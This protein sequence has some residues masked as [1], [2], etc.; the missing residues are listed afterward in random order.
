MDAVAVPALSAPAV[1]RPWTWWVG[2]LAAA[3]LGLVMLVAVWAKMLDPEAFTEQIRNE[4]LD[5]LLSASAVALVALF[6]EAGFGVG[7]LLGVRRLWLLVPGTILVA[8]LVFLSG[9]TYWLDAHGLLPETASCGCFG[10]LVQRTPAEAFWQDLALLVPALALSFVGRNKRGKMPKVRTGVALVAAAAV[11]AFAWK[12]PELPL[13]D[14]ATRLR[15]GVAIKDLCVGRGEE[16]VCLDRAV[17][18]LKT[19]DHLVVMGKLDDPAV[20]GAIPEL[21][22]LV[23]A[24]SSVV[25]VSDSPPEEHHRFYWQWGPTF[26]VSQADTALIR[27]LYRRLPRSFSLSGGRVKETYS[28]LPPMATPTSKP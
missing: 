24:G 17:P 22:E 21:N 11:A 3:F 20:T 18:E 1:A 15:P 26:S 6:L 7:L 19:G 5:F 10:N 13:D 2:T 28:G 14:L 9:R 23:A 16:A 12:A 27:P 8:F 25:L 4:K